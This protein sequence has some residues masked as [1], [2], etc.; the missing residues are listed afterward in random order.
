VT[1]TVITVCLNAARTLAAT[2][3]SVRSQL[4]EVYEYLIV[5]GGSTDGTLDIIAAAERAFHGK[6]R[7]TS[8]PDAG[9]YDAM[10]KGIAR[11]TGS[12]VLFLGAD[13]LMLDG[14]FS[15]ISLGCDTDPSVDLVYGDAYVVEPGGHRR[16][17]PALENARLVDGLPWVMPTCHQAC[18]FTAK[19]YR[20]LGG[21]DASFKIAGDYEFYVRFHQSGLDSRHI[22]V[23][24][25]AYSLEGVSSRLGVATA[26]EYRRAR[27]MHGA[28]PIRAYLLMTRSILFLSAARLARRVRAL[29]R[30]V[31]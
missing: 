29:E 25:V 9:I 23:P 11:A 12:H 19:S 6:L 30:F 13:D 31:P 10:N 3:E 5:D 18:V 20:E 26:N 8:E 2:M 21:F 15:A 17:K 24:L 14:A 27:V 4:D 7:W 16:L 1:T 28:G 22:S